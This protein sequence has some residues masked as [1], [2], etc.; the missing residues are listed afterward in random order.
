[1]LNVVPAIAV[2]LNVVA[3][4][5]ISSIIEIIFYSCLILPLTSLLTKLNPVSNNAA[6]YAQTSL[7]QLPCGT[8]LLSENA[9]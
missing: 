8:L 4:P 1:M 3:P 2:V 7:G 9:D 5:N 6:T